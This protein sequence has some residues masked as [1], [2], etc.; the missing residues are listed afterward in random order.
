MGQIAKIPLIGGFYQA[1]SVIANA[2]RCVNLYAEANP[3]DAPFPYTHY[4]TPGLKPLF[5]PDRPGP[6]R[7]AYTATTGELFYVVGKD[8]YFVDLT[9][10][11]N[12]IGELTTSAA[13]VSIIDNGSQGIIVDGTPFGFVLDVP[14]RSVTPYTEAGYLGSDR[15]DYL[16]GFFCFNQPQTR[17]FYISL[18]NSISIDP[19]DV[20]AKVGA[21]DMLVAVA[22]NERQAYLLGS[23]TSEVW[24]NAGTPVF[25]FQAIQ[26]A[27]IRHGIASPYCLALHDTIIYGVMQDPEGKGV[28]IALGGYGAKRISTPAIEQELSTY[29]T[30]NDA[31]AFTYQQS[32]HPFYCVSFPTANKTWVW[33]ISQEL[34]H[35]RAWCDPNG[36]EQRWRAVCGAYWNEQNVVGDWENGTLYSL[37]LEQYND[38]GG[39]I[40]R[41]RSFPHSVTNGRE[42]IYEQFQA[43][44]EVGNVLAGATEPLVSMRYSPTRGKTW[45]DPQTVSLGKTGDYTAV[46][47]W[48][49]QGQSRDMVYELFWSADVKTALNGAYAMVSPTDA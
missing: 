11:G 34:W 33:D 42:A 4:P 25:P 21:P 5:V 6:A 22:C 44:M 20:A 30:L 2:Q 9:Y 35:Q 40:V 19:T 48:R 13:P 12:K 38:F 29:S 32:G 41:R 8:I 31:V 3:Q 14:G 18:F 15:V 1:R 27:F 46:P 37:E 26:G 23:K 10:R 7:C 16:D 36:L 17:N 43:E 28:I 39:P 45:S 49:G 47:Q 24:G